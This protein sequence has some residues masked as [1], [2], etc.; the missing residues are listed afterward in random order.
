MVP[1]C[2]FGPTV[3]RA[4]FGASN[5]ADCAVKAGAPRIVNFAVRKIVR[6]CAADYL[7]FTSAPS[8][9]PKHFKTACP[10]SESLC[11]VT[12]GWATHL[13]SPINHEMTDAAPS[14]AVNLWQSLYC[15]FFAAP[16][17]W[18]RFP[19]RVPCRPVQCHLRILPGCIRVWR[20]YSW[21]L[22]L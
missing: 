22:M 17:T 6:I 11:C 10:A 9:E 18:A 5:V 20:G 15:P 8:R 1:L 4:S 7:A 13:K 12:T 14:E 2:K 3:S 19:C 16:A 21:P